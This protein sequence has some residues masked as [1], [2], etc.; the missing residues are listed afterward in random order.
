MLGLITSSVLVSI[1]SFLACSLDQYFAIVHPFTYKELVNEE[2]AIAVVIIVWVFSVTFGMLPAMGWNTGDV[3][4]CTLFNIVDL[5]YTMFM[6]ALSLFVTGPVIIIL[7][8]RTFIVARR[9]IHAIAAQEA[10]LSTISGQQTQASIK[11][12]LDVAITIFIAI[13]VFFISWLPF[14]TAVWCNK[15]IFES[16]VKCFCFM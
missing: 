8:V 9:H 1:L 14:Y 2:R 12:E 6:A 15:V 11:K 7:Y 10:A 16:Q 4:A 13:I 5:T 3:T